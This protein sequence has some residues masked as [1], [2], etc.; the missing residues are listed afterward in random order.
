MNVYMSGQ[1]ILYFHFAKI[2]SVVAA[3]IVL[4]IG[5]CVDVLLNSEASAQPNST[6]S[7]ASSMRPEVGSQKMVANPINFTGSIPLRSTI[8]KAISSVIKVPL[9][10]AVSTAQKLIGSNSSATLAAL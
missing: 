1:L 7:N 8:N 5:T 9:I 10:E 4:A 3:T 6:G 2:S